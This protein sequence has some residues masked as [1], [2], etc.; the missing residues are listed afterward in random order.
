MLSEAQALAEELDLK[1]EPAGQKHSFEAALLDKPKPKY[2]I[3]NRRP[4]Y[5]IEVFWN[6][7]ELM[8]WLNN[9]KKETN[10]G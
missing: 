4:T 5:D 10:N 2:V 3:K 9:R 1:L 8:S 6:L 7:T